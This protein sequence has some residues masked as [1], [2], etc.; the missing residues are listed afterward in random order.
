MLTQTRIVSRR[1]WSRKSP[2]IVEIRLEWNIAIRS[3]MEEMRG[4]WG[5]YAIG[6]DES[7][8]SGES[9]LNIYIEKHRLAQNKK[10]INGKMKKKTKVTIL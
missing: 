9:W 3:A 5:K 4:Q 6:K 10:D 2:E 8:K 1:R 7:L